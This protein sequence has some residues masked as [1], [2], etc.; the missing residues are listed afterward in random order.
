MKEV[1]RHRLSKVQGLTKTTAQMNNCMVAG[2]TLTGTMT[3]IIIT[4]QE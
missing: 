4:H 3:M 1:N 2:I